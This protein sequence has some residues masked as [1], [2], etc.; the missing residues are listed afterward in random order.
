MS[1]SKTVAFSG[2]EKQIRDAGLTQSAMI[3]EAIG[4]ALANAWFGAKRLTA[5]KYAVL[6]H[7][8][9]AYQRLTVQR[10]VAAH[11]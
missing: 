8:L 7:R 4:D 3:G 5:A 10:R 11:H 6:T 9:A 2:I 1:E